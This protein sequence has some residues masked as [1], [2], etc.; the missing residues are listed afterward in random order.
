MEADRQGFAG[1]TEDGAH[2]GAI[3]VVVEAQ[4][5]HF[6]V[7]VGQVLEGSPQLVPI[8]G[9]GQ[10]VESEVAGQL[11]VDVGHR[12]VPPIAADVIHHR[13]GGD[14]IQPAAETLVPELAPAD[15]LERSL[16][17]H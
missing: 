9:R 6:A 13:V 7:V 4:D 17:G 11:A 2:L 5:D 16:E 3:E 12:H 10:G 14:S 1:A 15:V 8:E